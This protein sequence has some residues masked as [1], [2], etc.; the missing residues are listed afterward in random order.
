MNAPEEI[1]GRVIDELRD[2]PKVLTRCA[3]TS[4]L[5]L[6]YARKA[7]YHTVTLDNE[8]R[9]NHVCSLVYAEPA[10]ADCF[11]AL[12][13]NVYAHYMSERQC[14]PPDLQ[15]WVTSTLALLALRLPNVSAIHFEYIRWQTLRGFDEDFLKALS[16]FASVSTIRFWACNFVAFAEFEGI[17][18][19][20]PG[21]RRLRLDSI[22]CEQ[23]LAKQTYTLQLDSLSIASHFSLRVLRDWL[24]KIKAPTTL[25]ELAF[26]HLY[27][28]S[29]LHA[30]GEI[31]ANMGTALQSLTVCC[32]FSCDGYYRLQGE[33]VSQ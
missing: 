22:T 2:H 1:V 9:A 30:A 32:R 3:L 17:L 10:I 26:E 16:N 28:E 19:A 13:F 7:L 12:K 18:L 31:L 15:S 25:R 29:D 6:Y 11:R 5:W 23:P 8:Q 33:C 4:R 20:F 24:L 14:P 21:L 27:D